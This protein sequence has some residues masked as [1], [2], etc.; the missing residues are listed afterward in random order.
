MRKEQRIGFLLGLVLSALLLGA[1]AATETATPVPPTPT[2]A[3]ELT[4]VP[5]TSTPVPPTTRS[6]SLFRQGNSR[7]AAPMPT[8]TPTMKKSR[9]TA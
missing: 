2:A 7:W 9:R 5:A 1:C 4:A 8:G 6:W 3:P